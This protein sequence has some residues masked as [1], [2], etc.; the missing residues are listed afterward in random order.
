M[1]FIPQSQ[2]R[3]GA[4]RGDGGNVA[5]DFSLQP[6]QGAQPFLIGGLDGHQDAVLGPPAEFQLIR[7]QRLVVA[8]ENDPVRGRI[9]PYC[10]RTRGRERRL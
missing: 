2:R 1:H 4:D 3:E 10:D 5:D 9:V 6:V 8:V 7:E